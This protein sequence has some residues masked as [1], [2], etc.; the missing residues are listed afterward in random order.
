[1]TAMS[2]DLPSLTVITKSEVDGVITQDRQG[3][4]DTIAATYRAVAADRVVIP[5][6]SFL[7]FPDRPRDRIIALPAYLGSDEPVA[8]IKWISSWPGNTESGRARASAVLILNDL[9]SGFPYS[10][11]E[12]STISATRTAAGAVLAAER[13][14]GERRAGKVAIIGAGLIAHTCWSILVDTGWEIDELAIYDTV[15]ASA[16]RFGEAAAHP[17]IKTTVAASAV[18]ACRDA[19]LVVIATVAAEPHLH[20]SALLAS[21][22]IVLHLSLRDLAPEL[23]VGSVNITDDVGHA[24]RE[25]TSLH[26][27]EL[28]YG[29]RDF[30]HG[31]LGALLDDPVTFDRSAPVVFSPFGLGVLD[32]ALGR[33]V[34]DAVVAGGGGR[35]I[36]D[37]FG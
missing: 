20:D 25:R 23:I 4:L 5:H 19:D 29:N 15:A 36:V 18:D 2:T 9:D 11:L 28:E 26:L 32:I 1:M 14:A 16:H 34:H 3:V 7:R 13:V 12:S 10:V 22:P 31:T 37:F 27:A 24:V 30:M 33:W 35:P 17:N 8:G 6:S 21:N